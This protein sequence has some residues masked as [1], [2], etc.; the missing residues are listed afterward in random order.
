MMADGVFEPD[1]GSIVEEAGRNGQVTERSRT[2]L[3]A[4]S[5]GASDL[6]QAEILV[7]SRP[8]KDDVS[9]S[10]AEEGGD[11]RD[12]NDA[13]FKVGE[14][15]VRFTNRGA[16]G[17][18]MALHT[19]G[20]AKKEKRP[21]FFR[22]SHGESVAPCELGDRRRGKNEREFEFGNGF[23]EHEEID[24][25]TRSDLREPFANKLPVSGACVQNRE[26]FLA[27]GFVS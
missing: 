21:A 20:L 23:T 17:H 9:L 22:G 24:R 3:V 11:L 6:F 26:S 8:I 4:I 10:Y 19:L 12:A 18:S 15:L 14:H 25:C 2:K 13:L 5:F 1:K 16:A 7:L 27:D